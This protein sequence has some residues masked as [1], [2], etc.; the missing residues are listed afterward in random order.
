MERWMIILVL[1]V[2][3][4][5][6]GAVVFYVIMKRLYRKKYEKTLFENHEDD[7]YNLVHYIGMA[8]ERTG[9]G[10]IKK[11]LLEQGWKKAQINYAM[12]L[13]YDGRTGL[14]QGRQS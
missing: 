11:N 8:A 9:E 5:F 12:R 14:N 3:F 4:L 6:A 13:Y 10:E 1:G 7:L 2:A